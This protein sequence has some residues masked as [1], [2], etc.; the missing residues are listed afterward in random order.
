MGYFPKHQIPISQVSRNFEPETPVYHRGI[1]LRVFLMK[2]SK[3]ASHTPITLRLFKT[4]LLDRL[5]L[6]HFKSYKT[7]IIKAYHHVEHSLWTQFTN[8]NPF[9]R[10]LCRQHS[11]SSEAFFFFFFFFFFPLIRHLAVKL[12]SI[13]SFNA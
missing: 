2:K 9:R 6:K 4:I 3:M 10:G 1:S 5:L 11:S 7:S 13:F 8:E 12:K